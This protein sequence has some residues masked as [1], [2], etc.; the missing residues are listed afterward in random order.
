MT[1]LPKQNKLP[2]QT[3][4]NNFLKNIEEV[5]QF[6]Y[7]GAIL[8]D[9]VELNAEVD[10]RVNKVSIAFGCLNKLVWYQPAIKHSTMFQLFK[11]VILSVLL[12]GCESWAPLNHHIQ[13][14]NTF[15]NRCIRTILGLSLFDKLRNTDLRRRANIERV[16]TILQR[17][18]LRWL[19]HIERMK[20]T[21]LPKQLLVSKFE[22]GKRPHGK[23][24][25]R[26][27]D[28]MNADLKSL[29]MVSSWRTKALNRSQWRKEVNVKLNALNQFKEDKEKDKKDRKKENSATI[30]DLKCLQCNK[31]CLN[32]TGLAN[33]IRLSH[34]TDFQATII[35]QFCGNKFKKQGMPN[36]KKKCQKT[37]THTLSAPA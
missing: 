36:H 11:A 18:R 16:E 15:I 24:R 30:T 7:L 1:I 27:H 9:E 13:R 8:T 35:C 17:R 25:Q 10:A 32:K 21:R 29:N 2:K 6:K 33:H 34:T 20:N 28:V 31:V 23:Q 26:W 14:L 22:E 3:S 37:A 19:G 12:Y 5:K 4:S